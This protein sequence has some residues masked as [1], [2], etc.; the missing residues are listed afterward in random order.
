LRLGCVKYLNA[1]PLIHGW[2]GAVVLDHPAALCR[3]LSD[4]ELDVALVSSFEFLRRPI[5]KVVDGIS[6]SSDGPVY[7][8][9]VACTGERSPVE[10]EL[11]PASETSVALLH[12]LLRERGET[13]KGVEI[14]TDVL[15]PFGAGRARLLIGDQAIRFRQRFGAA[16]RYWDLGDEWRRMTKLPFVY[17]LWLVRPELSNIEALGKQLRALRDQ[18]VRSIEQIIAQE[19]SFEPEFCRR[20]YRDNLRFNFGEREKRGLQEF[21]NACAK[22][23]LIPKRGLDLQLV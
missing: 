13:F 18:N 8:V 15:S 5:Y 21:A 7:S 4:G 23:N 10:I 17:A 6:I 1:R 14:T 3:S 9:I 2:P 16:Y 12:H 22:L 20:Y 11:D 19:K